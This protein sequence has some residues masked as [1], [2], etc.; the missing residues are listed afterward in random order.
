MPSF[1]DFYRTPIDDANR[2]YGLAHGQCLRRCR[3]EAASRAFR[4]AAIDGDIF[5]E[6]A[7]LRF[8]PFYLMLPMAAIYYISRAGRC[9]SGT[10]IF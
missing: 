2:A 1:Y 4:C 3:I 5:A 8:S 10:A 6:G 9:R 7:I